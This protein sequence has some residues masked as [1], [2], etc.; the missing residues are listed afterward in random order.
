M[1]DQRIAYTEKMIGAGHPTLADTLNRLSMIEH[2]A[3]GSH[4]AIHADS[5]IANSA[6]FVTLNITGSATITIADNSILPVKLVRGATTADATKFYRGDGGWFV[7][8]AATPAIR[9]VRQSFYA[10]PSNLT[11]TTPTDLHSF[12]FTKTSATSMLL[13]MATLTAVNDTANW[14]FATVHTAIFD[15]VNDVDGDSAVS[16]AIGWYQ[17]GGGGIV[18]P[19]A[20]LKMIS[21]IPS[22][23]AGSTTIGVKGY[24]TGPGAFPPVGV[25]Q[26][27]GLQIIVQEIEASGP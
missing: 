20:S 23:I 21:L 15:A 18:I 9:Q 11:L 6:T 10:G 26:Y 19:H 24:Y 22:L 7:P 2:K 27:S 16:T 1:A 14:G 25:P 13:V 4:G 5:I 17:S 12:S 8:T 3:D